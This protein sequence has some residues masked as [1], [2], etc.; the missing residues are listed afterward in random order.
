MNSV[1]NHTAHEVGHLIGRRGHVG[2]GE[3]NLMYAAGLSSNPCRIL[4]NEWQ[5]VNP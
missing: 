2:A 4:R 5:M 3:D 1:D